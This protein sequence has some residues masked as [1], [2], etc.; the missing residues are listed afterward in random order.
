[1]HSGIEC[2]LKVGM[3]YPLA[4]SGVTLQS[5]D[6]RFGVTREHITVREKGESEREKE[7]V[8]INGRGV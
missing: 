5:V 4:H 8:V 3:D 7:M 1:M 2:V 6:D